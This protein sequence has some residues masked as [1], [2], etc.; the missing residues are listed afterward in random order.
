MGLGLV[1]RHRILLLGLDACSCSCGILISPLN[2]CFIWELKRDNGACT[3]A[4][5]PGITWPGTVL[6]DSTFS[7]GLPPT[8]WQFGFSPTSPSSPW[9]ATLPSFLTLSKHWMWVREGWSQVH[10]QQSWHKPGSHHP[11]AVGLQH[12]PWTQ[13]VQASHSPPVQAWWVPVWRLW[14]QGIAYLPL[15]EGEAE[16]M[17]RA[18]LS[19]LSPIS[20]WNIVSVIGGRERLAV[21]GPLS[22][23]ARS[24]VTCEGLHV[25]C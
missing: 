25:P 10:T 18:W 13:Q 19:F 20:T 1:Q 14:S 6:H 21:R 11:T 12:K 5:E 8:H 4:L 16:E 9:P 15:R 22:H 2:V 24:P 17:G 3:W 7:A 23:R